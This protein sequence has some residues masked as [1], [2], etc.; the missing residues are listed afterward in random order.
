MTLGGI[1]KSLGRAVAMM[2][3]GL[4]WWHPAWAYR[5]FD[6]TDADVA[7]ARTLE[8]AVAPA[9]YLEH[10]EVRSMHLPNLSLTFGLGGGYEFG[11]EGI[12]SVF[13]KTDDTQPQ[14][15]FFEWAAAIKRL[16]R[17]GN[18]QDVAGPSIATEGEVVVPTRGQVRPGTALAVVMSDESKTGV[19]HLGVEVARTPELEN[20]LSV[21]LILETLDYHGVRPVA[22]LATTGVRHALPENSAL[23]G[24]IYEAY[25]GLAFDVGVK[26]GKAGDDR[27][28]ELRTGASWQLGPRT[29]APVR[30]WVKK[31]LRRRHY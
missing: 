10:G 7:E 24:V 17:R 11:V 21:V 25:E 18:L 28:T 1:L 16:L 29:T 12:N 23:I 9:E 8:I 4:A 20:E 2:I 6:F 30:H 26:F 14:S 5:P 15:S 3:L 31:H 27:S 19:A 13:L 22:E